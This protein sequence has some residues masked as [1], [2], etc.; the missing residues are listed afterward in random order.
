V[1]EAKVIEIIA[2]AGLGLAT[3][4]A[5]VVWLLISATAVRS[6]QFGR[7]FLAV[8]VALADLIAALIIGARLVGHPFDLHRG[9]S[10][11]LLLPIIVLPA[12]MAFGAWLQVRRL[13]A[14]ALEHASP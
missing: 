14:E 5:G 10:T 11:L 2:L 12:V 6:R 9:V 4:F 3:G 7:G 1:W 13:E 8:N